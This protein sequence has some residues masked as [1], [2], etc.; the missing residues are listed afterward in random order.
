VDDDR[1]IISTHRDGGIHCWDVRFTP[2]P[3]RSLNVIHNLREVYPHV[4]VPASLAVD[5]SVLV[6][7]SNHVIIFRLS[8]SSLAS[9]N[10]LTRVA[11]YHANPGRAECDSMPG[12]TLV[13]RSTSPQYCFARNQHI[14]FADIQHGRIRV[15]PT[16]IP[17]DGL[18]G[19]THHPRLPLVVA[20]SMP[21]SGQ[22]NLSI[23][24]PVVVGTWDL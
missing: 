5:D 17:I 15:L 24:S 16:R 19:L 8:N 2:V 10:I 4:N 12:R 7:A 13:T 22:A 20:S 3:V 9:L 6:P 14:R 1:V 18:D 23:G 21:I 11:T